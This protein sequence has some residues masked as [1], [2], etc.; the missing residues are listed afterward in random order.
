M[1]ESRNASR[2]KTLL[3]LAVLIPLLF[4]LA[5][6]SGCVLLLAAPKRVDLFTSLMVLSTFSILFFKL[7]LEIAVT[8]KSNAEAFT[9]NKQNLT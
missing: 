2:P 8:K 7:H 3:L 9:C 5:M 6:S 1:I 4:L